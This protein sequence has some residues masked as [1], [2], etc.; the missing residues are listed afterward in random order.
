MF[1]ILDIMYFTSK[2][3]IIMYSGPYVS[4]HLFVTL[5]TLA[6][7]VMLKYSKQLVPNVLLM[8]AN[9]PKA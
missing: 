7:F 5:Q 6:I 3:N 2:V 1:S 9:E 4:L 8:K